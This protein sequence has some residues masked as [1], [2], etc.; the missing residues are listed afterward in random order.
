LKHFINIPAI[1]LRSTAEPK[2]QREWQVE[3]KADFM[4]APLPGLLAHHTKYQRG[5]S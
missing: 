1:N 2:R 5:Q 3:A 4:A